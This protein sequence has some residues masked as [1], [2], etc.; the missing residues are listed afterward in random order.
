MIHT[1]D[2]LSQIDQKGHIMLKGIDPLLSADLLKILR[3]MGH[4]DEVAVVDANFTATTLGA[5]KP[6][7]RLM[8]ADLRAACC[9]ILSVLPL[10]TEVSHAVG[11][12]K[13]SDTPDGFV[14]QTQ[15]H[16][17]DLVASNDTHA[18]C[19]AIERFAFYER[20]KA[21]YA[22]VQTSEMQP[23]ANFIFTKG[24]IIDEPLL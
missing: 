18:Q 20:V 6:V 17:I 4:G 19:Q 14:S 10:D 12:M 11:F 13:M 3:E 7:I 5:G 9:A 1:R 2:N 23:F 16:V 15:Q 8:G 22:I 21:V 24:V